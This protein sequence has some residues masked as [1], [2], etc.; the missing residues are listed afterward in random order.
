[1]TT[2]LVL[3]FPR[4]RDRAFVRRHAALMATYSEGAAE[5]YL[6]TQLDVQRRT[7]TKRGVDPAVAEEHIGALKCAIRAEFGRYVVTRGGAA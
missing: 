6:A 2:G 4:V 7:M 5:K 1:M 3:P